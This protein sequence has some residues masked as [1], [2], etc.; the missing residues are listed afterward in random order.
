MQYHYSADHGVKLCC[1]Q[2][3]SSDR[4]DNTGA[5]TSWG[6]GCI[7]AVKGMSAG[8]RKGNGCVQSQTYQGPATDYD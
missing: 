5:S 1:T 6:L 3:M 2:S 4:V 7:Y 8:D